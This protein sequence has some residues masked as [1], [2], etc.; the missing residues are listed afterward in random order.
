MSSAPLGSN[1]YEEAAALV[2]AYVITGG[3][4]RPPVEFAFESLVRATERAALVRSELV[5][6]YADIVDLSTQ[7]V[8]IAEVA[9]QVAIPLGV[10]QVLVGDMASE[11]LLELTVPP[12]HP[13][14]DIGLI[15]RLIDGVRAL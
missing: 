14:D 1:A 3:R 4:T 7:P 5:F 13:G 10:A 8:S 11:G 15:K 9:A 6:E 2:R 12:S